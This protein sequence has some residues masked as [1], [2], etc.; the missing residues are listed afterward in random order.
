MLNDLTVPLMRLAGN[1]PIWAYA[2]GVIGFWILSIALFQNMLAVSKRVLRADRQ[3]R[4]QAFWA[5]KKWT[6]A[7]LFILLNVFW[8]YRFDRWPVVLF[9]VVLICAHTIY[10]N[11]VAKEIAQKTES[12]T[13][14]PLIGVVL[15]SGLILSNYIR[16]QDRQE[17]MFSFIH[18]ADLHCERRAYELRQETG[19]ILNIDKEGEDHLCSLIRWAADVSYD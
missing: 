14:V 11:V 17:R 15:F 4:F 12:N 10:R 13:L 2:L 6:I 18:K 16:E 9:A 5:A 3:E 8:V 7:Y 1:I 19:V